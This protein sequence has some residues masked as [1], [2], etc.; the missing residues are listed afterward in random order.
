MKKAILK[1]ILLLV[2]FSGKLFAQTASVPDAAFLSY[3][4]NNYPQTIDISNKLLTEEAEKITGTLACAGCGISNLQGI[5]YFIAATEVSF[6]SNNV[7]TIPDIAGLTALLSLDLSSNKLKALPSLNGLTNL[8]MLNVSNNLLVSLPHPATNTFLEEI[9]ASGNLLS[10]VPD[11][12]N[13]IN[14]KTLN[15]QDNKVSSLPSLVNLK[16]LETLLIAENRIST[17]PDLSK[18]TALIYLNASNNKL[19]TTPDLS[20][21]TALQE[22]I[23]DSNNLTNSP[24]LTGLNQLNHVILE[25]N[26]LTFQD[27]IPFAAYPGYD[28]V[29][30]FVPQK[31]L[32]VGT[33]IEAVEGDSLTLQTTIDGS[34]TGVSYAWYFQNTL[35]ATVQKDAYTIKKVAVSDSGFYFARL[36]HPAFPG[37]VL[38][39]DSFH[40]LVSPCLDV[41]KITYAST[42]INCV[43]PGTIT[44]NYA[45]STSGLVYTL[46]DQAGTVS[47]SATG[48][49]TGLTKPNYTLKIKNAVC[50]RAYPATITLQQNDCKEVFITPGSVDE[51]SKVSFYDSG[52]VVI[53]DKSGRVVKKLTIPAS[54]DGRNEQGKIVPGYYIANINN[55]QTYV[56]ISV[57]Y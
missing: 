8:R 23:L 27:I 28:T 41:S 47:S 45:A 57:I 22:I 44:V 48:L 9:N 25:N 20:S 35:D 55:G 6:P 3:L 14:L 10:S 5:Q 32:K 21:N 7:A 37:L 38:E 1:I 36:T 46:I 24:D 53:Y 15:I 30:S 49:F 18:N 12:S 17:L 40:L 51:N 33:E 54:W 19:S 31:K 2:F 52:K 34:V 50:E 43:T 4:K 26:Y 39:T 11:L 29:F 42:E 16:A 56:R 13:L